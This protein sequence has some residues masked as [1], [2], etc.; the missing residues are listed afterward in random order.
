M[1][2]DKVLDFQAN[3]NVYINPSSTTTYRMKLVK[4]ED[5]SLI[6]YSES[7]D[8]DDYKENLVLLYRVKVTG[9]NANFKFC[10]KVDTG[11]YT[12]RANRL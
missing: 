9:S 10:L 5:N 3:L 4:V 7:H 8:R 11:N 2:T 1:N 12:I 6:A